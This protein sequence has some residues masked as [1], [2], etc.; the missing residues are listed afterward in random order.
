MKSLWHRFQL[1]RI[2]ARWIWTHSTKTAQE[3]T[4][5]IVARN[6]RG[7]IFA[8]LIVTRYKNGVKVTSR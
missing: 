7:R 5:S 2:V 6:L 1:R 8:I 4:Y 3:C